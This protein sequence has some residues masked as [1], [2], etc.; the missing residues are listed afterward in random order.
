MSEQSEALSVNCAALPPST[1]RL[2]ACQNMSDMLLGWKRVASCCVFV[3]FCLQAGVYTW[4]RLIISWIMRTMKA[5]WLDI[6]CEL[7]TG[8]LHSTSAAV[9]GSN[10]IMTRW[11]RTS[12][13]FFSRPSF[14]RL[15]S[16]GSFPTSLCVSNFSQSSE[17]LHA[18]NLSFVSACWICE[19][20]LSW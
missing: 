11:W 20:L 7:G 17:L 18:D 13:I 12:H 19:Q 2:A 4:E 15:C 3:I 16:D 5:L 10:I 6:P 1:P 8:G 9:W 14:H